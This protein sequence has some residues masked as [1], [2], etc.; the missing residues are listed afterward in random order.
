M[1]VKGGNGSEELMECP[2]PSH[3]VLW[4]MKFVKENPD[5]KKKNLRPKRAFKIK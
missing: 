4:L 5:R 3:A 1:S 2:P